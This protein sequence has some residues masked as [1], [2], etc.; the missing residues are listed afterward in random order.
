MT[1]GGGSDLGSEIGVGKRDR[2]VG[3]GGGFGETL[4]LELEED[5]SSDKKPYVVEVRDTMWWLKA[6]LPIWLKSSSGVMVGVGLNMTLK[7]TSLVRLEISMENSYGFSFTLHKKPPVQL[8]RGT[9]FIGPSVW[10]VR[11]STLAGS[12]CGGFS[13]GWQP[14]FE[15]QY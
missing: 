12:I 2:T 11:V 13:P 14:E 10:K 6:E 9:G 5:G 7:L 15:A 3:R 1:S 4:V 8:G